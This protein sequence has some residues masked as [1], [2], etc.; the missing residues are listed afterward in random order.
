MFKAKLDKSLQ[1]PTWSQYPLSLYGHQIAFTNH[2]SQSLHLYL[3]L[4]A[5]F[6]R[7][8]C[9]CPEQGR[10][11]NSQL[12]GFWPCLGQGQFT[13]VMHFLGHLNHIFPLCLSNCV[14]ILIY[15]MGINWI[16][17]IG[18]DPNSQLSSAISA[19]ILL[20]ELQNHK[21]PTHR[22]PVNGLVMMFRFCW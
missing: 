12:F 2:S 3:Y 6:C 1:F 8:N 10:N 9:P 5:Y 17:L 16:K 15:I 19:S 13:P 7:V 22:H 21:Q 14:S 11:P 20:M 4:V 18:G